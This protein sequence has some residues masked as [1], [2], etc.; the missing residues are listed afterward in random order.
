[1]VLPVQHGIIHPQLCET[2]GDRYLEDVLHQGQKVLIGGCAP[3]M[4]YKLFR[5]AFAKRGMDVKN[6]LVPI[7]V[8]DMT[9]DEAIEKVTQELRKHGYEIE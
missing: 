7:D 9:T 1:M 8:R 4:Q 2:D 3:V 5:D 6:D